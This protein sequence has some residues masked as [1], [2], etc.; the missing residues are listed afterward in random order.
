M[1]HRPPRLAFVILYLG[2]VSLPASASP[3]DNTPFA[4][5]IP[6]TDASMVLTIPAVGRPLLRMP[7]SDPAFGTTITRI[8]GDTGTPIYSVA[9]TWGADARHAYSK[10]QPWN[11]DGTLLVVQN[12]GSGTPSKLFLDGT[13]YVPKFGTCSNDPL[14]DYR[15]HPSRAHA[16]TMINVNSAGTELM[17]Y[18]VVTCTKTRSWPLPITASYGIGSG[19]GNPSNDGRFVCVAN[20]SQMVVIDMD[21][22][23]P[24]APWPARRMGPICALLPCDI[25][26]SSPSGD[27]RIGN[28]SI[29]PSGR[30]V[31]VKFS[32]STDTTQDLHRIYEVDPVTLALKPHPMDVSALR[33]GSF[34]ARPD[35]WTFPLK[36]ADMALDPF[37]GDEDVLIGGRSCPGSAIGHVVKVRLRDGKV[38][39]LTSPSNEPSFEHASARNIDRPGWVYVGFYR[40]EGKKF[41]DEVV[42]VKLDGSGSVERYS[43][44]RSVFSGCYRCESHPVPSRDGHRIL[45]ASNWAE[46]C[47]GLCGASGDIK[48]YVVSLPLGAVAADPP[49]TLPP[50]PALAV[51]LVTPR[52]AV[53]RVAIEYAVPGMEHVRLEMVNA[54]GRRVRSRDLGTP[55]PGIHEASVERGS[56]LPAGVYWVRLTAGPSVATER[57]VFVG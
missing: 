15:W 42:A 36:H 31:D 56:D 10:Q 17:W 14:Y 40:A 24:Y 37:D 39:A 33:C 34:E 45:F 19:E 44:K 5:P 28:I 51:R 53:S 41:S 25:N 18:D 13:T 47:G 4:R 55:G 38:T 12:R 54:A 20:A 50:G 1:T 7:M 23:P 48:D 6:L 46:N 27:C 21:P 43:H 8:T 35:G 52:P 16:N 22:A 9:G 11:A 49:A 57:V 30:Y 26:A 3:V 2:C 29:S 32:A